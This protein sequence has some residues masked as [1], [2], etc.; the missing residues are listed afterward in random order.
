MN[1]DSFFT[2]DTAKRLYEGCRTLP[3]I[4]YHCHLSPKEIYEDKPF[5]TIGGMWLS[6]DHYKWRLMR[7][8]GIDEEKITGSAPIEE[9]FLSYAEALQYAAGNPLYHW[10]HMELSK[11]FGIDTNLSEKTAKDVWERANAYIKENSLSPVKLITDSGVE[12][13]C[14]TDDPVDSLEYHIKL[15]EKALPFSVLPSFRTDRLL[16]VRA[17]GYL[18][19]IKELEKVSGVEITSLQG[20]KEAVEKRLLFFIENGCR[21]TDMGIQDFPDSVLSE[22][23]AKKAYKSILEGKEITDKEYGGLLG[24]LTVFLADIYCKYGLIMQWHFAVYRNANTSLYKKLGADC[25][26]DC[27]G[28]SVSGKQLMVMLDKINER[29]MPNLILY[30]LNSANAEQIASAAGAFPRVR[31]GTAWWFCD[32]KRGIEQQLKVISENSPIGSFLGMLTD[33]RSF[34]SYARHDY[35]RMILCEFLSKL[36]DEEGYPE[37]LAHDIAYKVCYGN[38]KELIKGGTK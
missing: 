33:S 36:V 11:Y 34:T 21:C 20:L 13:V 38:I 12:V 5:E 9:K 10:S 15:K 2:S 22:E 14:T 17:D 3:I 25:G 23:D 37:D 19:Y 18:S 26:V 6:G 31:L 35:F 27:V 1:K 29:G 8:Y 4:D 30:T 16:L 7:T 32:H 24:N 28:D